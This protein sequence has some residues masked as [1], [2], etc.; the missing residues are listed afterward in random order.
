MIGH[1]VAK[2]YAKALFSLAIE[3][4]NVEEIAG[5]L[6]SLKSVASS[7]PKMLL[8][9]ADERV[10]LVRRITATKQIAG[11]LGINQFTENFLKLLI[12][13]G[14]VSLFSLVVDDFEKRHKQYEKIAHA[15]A[16]IANKSMTSVIQSNIEKI[17]GDA[18]RVKAECNVSVN[19]ELLGG[20]SLKLG[21]I[22]YD[23]SIKG[24]IEKM[25]EGLGHQ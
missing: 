3:N 22:H 14:R 1:V 18:L 5:N 7:V 17:I 25:K 23:A 9:L 15:D 20:F 8:A 11:A 13:K 21:D 24:R 16:I 2:R 6:S 10:S 19:P 4:R 12:L